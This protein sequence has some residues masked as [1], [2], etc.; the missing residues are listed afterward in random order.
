VCG[1]AKILDT[2]AVNLPQVEGQAFNLG[3]Q[4]QAFSTAGQLFPTFSALMSLAPRLSLSTQGLKAFLDK[5]TTRGLALATGFE[6]YNQLVSGVGRG[7]TLVHQKISIAT[8][9]LL[10]RSISVRH[11]GIAQLGF[12]V[13]GVNAGG[14]VCPVLITESMALPVDTGVAALHTL[15]PVKIN[16]VELEGVESVTIDFGISEFVVSSNGLI[17]PRLAGVT[18]VAPRVSVS[19]KDSAALAAF[20]V[21]TVPGP[22]AQGA[23]DSVIFLRKKSNDGGNVADATAEHISFTIDQGLWVP[24]SKN[25]SHPGELST[26]I[27]CQPTFDGTN[28]PLVMSTVAAIT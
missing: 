22:L 15:G 13:I 17:Y 5:V 28:E 4:V 14:T 26:T 18:G 3:A 9:L 11:G 12:D 1:P 23:T 6:M 2:T 21:A 24:G 16:G 20:V 25:G 27:E 10:P 19:C 7:G 8:G